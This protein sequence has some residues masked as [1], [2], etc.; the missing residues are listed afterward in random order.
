MVVRVD[1]NP[2]ILRWAR[3]RSRLDPDVFAE[4]FPRFELWVDGEASPTLKQLE[5]FA[6]RTH[7]PLGY[8]FLEQPP[9]EAVPLPDFR[10]VADDLVEHPSPDL[11]ST[12]YVCQA[13]Q[14]W[15]RNH[16]LM[17]R[18]EPLSFVG[19]MEEET[20]IEEAARRLS[21]LLDWDSGTRDQAR[22]RGD[23]LTSLRERAESLGL[24]VMISG[25]VGSNTRR[26]LDPKEFRG[27]TLADPYAGL[28]FVNGSESK[29]A[30]VFTL[31]HEMAH[32]LLGAS[33]LD[34]L[35]PRSEQRHTVERWCNRV[36]AEVLVPM[37]EFRDVFVPDAELRVQLQPLAER[38]RVSTQVIIGRI[39]E[40]GYLS[41]DRY[42]EELGIEKMRVAAIATT[43]GS[44]GNFY[45][46]KPVQISKRFASEVVSSALAGW[47]P[48]TEAFR[49]LE[50][51]RMSTFDG[52][53]EQLEVR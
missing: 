38:F 30:Q 20:P 43:G 16:Q 3:A 49:L 10:T 1:V 23:A 52:L 11:L 2:E 31:V 27:F 28:I 18:E 12:V 33:G 14:E 37:V 45:Y 7:T 44:G 9:V 35:E 51:K 47:T 8:F 29:A 25:I 36:A 50:I 13:R 4:R 5:S 17:N 42:M 53:A 40:A 19:S 26:K 21:D 15:Y 24:L 39:R 32:L 48:Y 6:T 46:T 34:D 41:W 22:S